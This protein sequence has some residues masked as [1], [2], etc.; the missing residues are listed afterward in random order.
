MKPVV[1][2]A[3]VGV[4][5]LGVAFYF[6][7]SSSRPSL[8]SVSIAEA[9]WPAEVTYLKSR[10]AA[11]GLPAL[12]EEGMVLHTH[13]HLDVFVH[14]EKVAI[15]S[16]IGIHEDAPAFISPL[17]SHDTSGVIHVESPTVETF[18]LGQF[19][20]V[21][22]VRLDAACIGGYCTDDTNALRIYVNGEVY[23]GDPRALELTPHGIIVVTYGT[24][25]EIPNPVPKSYTFPEGY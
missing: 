4:L 25:A 20:N 22:G 12:A 2:G 1:I 8:A 5:L 15:P 24:E 23:T 21:W 13:Q 16:G 18:T 9:P 17:H 7:V 11:I 10:L 19:F 3:A 6:F 14:G